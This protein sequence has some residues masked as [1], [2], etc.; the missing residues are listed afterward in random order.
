MDLKNAKCPDTSIEKVEADPERSSQALSSAS[1]GAHQGA[2]SSPESL[3]CRHQ[4]PVRRLPLGCSR[5]LPRHLVV[6]FP[7]ASST[8]SRSNCGFF[9]YLHVDLLVLREAP[10]PKA[11]LF[12][13]AANICKMF[14]IAN[15]RSVEESHQL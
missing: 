6:A 7:S 14:T 3:A 4:Q 1:L 12:H 10:A 5:I 13:C 15:S 11:F 2:A 8:R 9:N